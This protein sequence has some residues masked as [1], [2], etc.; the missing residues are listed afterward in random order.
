MNCPRC[1]GH[2][3]ATGAAIDSERRA[4]EGWPACMWQHLWGS[5]GF[6]PHRPTSEEKLCCIKTVCLRPGSVQT[7]SGFYAET[8]IKQKFESDRLFCFFLRNVCKRKK[9]I[10]GSDGLTPKVTLVLNIC[11]FALSFNLLVRWNVSQNLLICF[12]AG[13]RAIENVWE[14]EEPA[15]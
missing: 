8:Q 12:K 14:G 7:P 13:K 15:K 1:W 9:H 3:Q 6:F 10:R 5:E 4:R 2:R 11:W